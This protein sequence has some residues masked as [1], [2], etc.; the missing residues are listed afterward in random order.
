LKQID[1]NNEN[2]LTAEID[3]CIELAE[4]IFAYFHKVEKTANGLQVVFLNPKHLVVTDSE[5]LQEFNCFLSVIRVQ[6]KVFARQ[7]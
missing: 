4:K 1:T 5:Q 2:D 7:F 3:S 6:A